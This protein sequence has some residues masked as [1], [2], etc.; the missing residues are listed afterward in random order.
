MSKIR[1]LLKNV[2]TIENKFIKR[3]CL[4]LMFPFVV[5]TVAPM[6][7]AYVIIDAFGTYKSIWFGHILDDDNCQ[8]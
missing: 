6:M 1:G 3:L 4:C 5:L 8:N 7:M 2:S